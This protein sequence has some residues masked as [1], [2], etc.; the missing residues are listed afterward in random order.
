[1]KF[2]GF[3]VASVVLACAGIAGSAPRMWAQEQGSPAVARQAPAPADQARVFVFV[4]RSEQH[5]K[6]SSREVF[7]N[8][9]NDFLEYLKEKNVA[10]A[11]DE[12]GGRNHAESATPMET[13]FNIARDAQASSVLYVVVDRPVTKWLKMTVQ[14][15][16]LSRK[17]LW[18]EEA[19]NG[20]GLSGGHGFEVTT[21][22]LY[23]LLDKRIGQEGLP[24]V[25]TAA[26]QVPQKL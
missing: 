23:T 10:I 4:Q 14:C 1:M 9:L 24:I 20:G 17:Q 7:E 19:S 8:V 2:T 11:V 26:G 13:V 6:R 15:F 12:F 3:T 22:K 25:I 16:D 5:A 21:K 18:Q